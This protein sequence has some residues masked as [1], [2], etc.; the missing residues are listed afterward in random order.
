VN[1]TARFSCLRENG[2]TCK[3]RNVQSCYVAV[4][5]LIDLMSVAT[6][7][8]VQMNAKMGGVPWVATNPFKRKVIISCYN[9]ILSSNDTSLLIFT[10]THL[11]LVKD[12]FLYSNPCHVLAHYDRRIRRSPFRE[13]GQEGPKYWCYCLDDGQRFEPILF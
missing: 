6:K 3:R 1:T 10:F 12:M 4:F 9:R 8:V 11:S 2:A 13:A 5:M 7:V